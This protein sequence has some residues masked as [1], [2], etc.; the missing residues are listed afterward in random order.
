VRTKFDIYISINP[1]NILRR[2]HN[3]NFQC[4]YF[5]TK[6]LNKEKKQSEAIL[7]QMLPKPVAECLKQNETVDAE[8]FEE[9]TIL[10]N[11]IVGFTRISA[12]CSP[13]QVTQMLNILFSCFDSR[14]E[15]YD[16]YKVETIGDGYMVASGVY[17]GLLLSRIFFLA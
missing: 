10:Q 3:F 13:L 12:N 6:A 8:Q 2:T 15:L 5:R 1:I 16:V 14:I 9:C 4:L 7:Y 17:L 11:D